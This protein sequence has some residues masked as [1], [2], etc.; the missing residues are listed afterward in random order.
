MSDTKSCPHC[1]RPEATATDWDKARFGPMTP[2]RVR[3][4]C[5]SGYGRDNACEEAK[6]EK[7]KAARR[8]K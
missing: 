4:I 2:A 3:K 6:A 8:A 1:G 5:W 7:R